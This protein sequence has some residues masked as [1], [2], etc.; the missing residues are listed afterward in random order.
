MKISE[1]NSII[2]EYNLNSSSNLLLFIKEN[3]DRL[4]ENDLREIAEIANSNRLENAAYYTDSFIVNE[5]IDNLPKINKKEITVL[6]PSVGTGSFIY[7]FIEKFT[8]MYQHIT[9]ILNDI[10]PVSLKITKFFLSKK[11]LPD[12]VTIK[13]TN[14]DFLG[15]LVF[16]NIEFDYIIGNPP[17]QRIT[18]KVAE[19][20]KNEI[21]N[22]AGQFYLKASN[23]GSIIGMVMPK[24]LLST[25]EYKQLRTFLASN[26]INT[27][28]DFGEKGFK[29]ILIETIAIITGWH[30]NCKTKIISHIDGSNTEKSQSYI[31]DQKFPSWLIYRNDFFDYIAKHMEFN[32]FTVSRDRQITNSMLSNSGDIRVIKSKNISNDGKSILD[33]PGYDKYINKIQLKKLNVSKIYNDNDVYLVPNMTYYPRMMKKSQSFIVNGSVAILK[34]K[35]GQIINSKQV[36]FFSTADY[37]KFYKIARNKGTRS[38]NIDSLSVF[39]FGKFIMG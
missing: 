5:I 28:I 29:G 39:W 32:I 27:I 9:I 1:I 38:L 10:D 35:P 8:S 13:Y 12:N 25:N 17:F 18:A 6:E 37:R 31:T 16:Y 36:A 4:G 14:Y 19:T 34:L 21:T 24:N 33:I 23:I 20:Y 22:L 30:S 15:D 7:P 11:N 26:P 2:R 3:W